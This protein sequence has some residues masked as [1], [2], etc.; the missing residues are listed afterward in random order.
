M[1]L[2][3]IL[4]QTVP[5]LGYELV[6]VELSPA[7]LIRVFIDK[8]D[9]GVSVDD[10]AEVSSHLSRV[11]QVEEIDYNR[12]E[13]SSPG[14]ERPLKKIADYLRFCGRLVKIKTLELY[15][16]QKVF[17][18]HIYEVSG[19]NITLELENKQLITFNISG[20]SRARLLFEAKKA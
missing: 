6:D 16:N 19:D 4:E 17:Q 1:K 20:I 14:L 11:F 2:L 12:L 9:G 5:G 13:I 15:D 10:C 7:K 8:A 18:G 3:K